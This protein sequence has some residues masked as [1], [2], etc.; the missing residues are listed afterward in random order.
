MELDKFWVKYIKNPS[1]FSSYFDHENRE[2]LYHSETEPHTHSETRDKVWTVKFY[3]FRRGYVFVYR[4]NGKLI[5]TKPKIGKNYSFN[6]QRLHAVIKKDNVSKFR[7]RK[8]WERNGFSDQKVGG[9]ACVF[10]F[11]GEDTLR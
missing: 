11:I 3:Y 10:E 1:N 4:L 7:N 2:Y 9:L 6:P 8:F 5:I